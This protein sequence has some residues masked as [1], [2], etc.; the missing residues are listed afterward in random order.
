MEGGN[1]L[2][3]IPGTIFRMFLAI[4][5]A[6]FFIKD[7]ELIREKVAG[8][9]PA[10]MRQKGQNVRSSLTKAL[11]G[12]FRGQLIIMSVVGT[13]CIIGLVVLRSP[14]AILV[15]LGIAAFDIIPI[16][17]AGG[18]LIP[19]AIISFVGGNTTFGIGLLA[20]SVLCFLCRQILEPKIVGKRIGLH[21][22]ILLMSVYLGVVTLGAIGILAG[23]FITLVIKIILETKTDVVS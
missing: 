15:G 3:A 10:Q 12:W 16:L 4:I 8:L 17:G 20:I 5:S 19:W 7:K 13:V 22:I 1:F 11:G 23:P 18:I 2:T 9:F 14:Y 21:P 6:F